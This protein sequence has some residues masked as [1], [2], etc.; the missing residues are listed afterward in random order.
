M[1]FDANYKIYNGYLYYD[2]YKYKKNCYNIKIFKFGISLT[3]LH[4]DWRGKKVSPQIAQ[5]LKL[6]LKQ[7]SLI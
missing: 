3:S 4:F 7:S 2:Y 6:F 5:I 1:H